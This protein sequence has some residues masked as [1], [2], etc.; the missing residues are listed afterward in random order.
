MRIKLQRGNKSIHETPGI[1]SFGPYTCFALERP[2]Y[3]N[4]RFLGQVPEGDYLVNR[5]TNDS[6]D[7]PRWILKTNRWVHEAIQ[8]VGDSSDER[9]DILIHVAN[10]VKEIVGCIGLGMN[11]V[12]SDN[13]MNTGLLNSA[14]AIKLFDKFWV[15]YAESKEKNPIILEIRD[16]K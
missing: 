11:L 12:V 7:R 6:I 13:F 16:P 1:F 14:T 4:A 3:H 5:H 9:Y 8:P 2:P 15:E 10:E